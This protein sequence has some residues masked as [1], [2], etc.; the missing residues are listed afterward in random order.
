VQYLSKPIPTEELRAVVRDAVARNTEAISERLLLD[1]T[2]KA[3]IQALFDVLQPAGPV[4]FARG[5]RIRTLVGELCRQLQLQSHWE[6]EVAAMASQLGAVTI[7]PSVLQ[8]LDKGLPCNVDEQ[9]MVD[10]MPGVAVRLLRTMPMLGDVVEIVRALA[11]SNRDPS[12][13][14]TL[15]LVSGAV[16]VLRTAMDFDTLL[17]RRLEVENAITVLECRENSSLYVLAAL[18]KSEGPHLNLR[19]LNRQATECPSSAASPSR[20]DSTCANSAPTRPS[21]RSGSGTVPSRAARSTSAKIAARVSAPR[22]DADP[23]NPWA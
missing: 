16:N 11:V 19:S 6:I 20:T 18:R 8:K 4:A 17:S 9:A 22:L 3:G 2:L 13:K 7:P 14:P 15:P 21:V 12:H 23:F 10:A 1:K 5:A